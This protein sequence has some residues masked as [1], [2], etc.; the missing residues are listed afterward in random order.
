MISIVLTT[1]NEEHVFR[2]YIN[3]V[4]VIELLVDTIKKDNGFIVPDRLM[5]EC[6]HS[7]ERALNFDMFS[8]DDKEYLE[9]NI[10]FSIKSHFL[11]Y[12]G[13]EALNDL[14]GY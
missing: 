2:D 6:L 9:N 1:T 8:S 10:D 11:K 13:E 7:I 14:L 3:D 4:A 12:N 5:H